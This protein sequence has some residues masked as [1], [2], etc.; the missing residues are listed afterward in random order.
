M[1]MATDIKRGAMNESRKQA[2]A[3]QCTYHNQHQQHLY[4]RSRQHI[5]NA[6]PHKP[7]H[8]FLAQQIGEHATIRQRQRID[9][10][11]P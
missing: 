2:R 6:M 11:Y 10:P 4:K 7:S 9:T 5:V 8:T 3:T 1:T